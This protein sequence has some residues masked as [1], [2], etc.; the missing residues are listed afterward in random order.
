M[1]K[2]ETNFNRAHNIKEKKI[3]V[4]NPNTPPKLFSSFLRASMDHGSQARPS[5]YAC[6]RSTWGG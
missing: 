1:P 5:K 6:R 4:E 2:N 3:P